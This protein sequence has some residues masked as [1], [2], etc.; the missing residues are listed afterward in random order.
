MKLLISEI[1]H[2]K[3][4]KKLCGM[5]GTAMTEADEFWKIYK[6]DVRAI[7]PNRELERIEFPDVIYCTE[8][9]KYAAIAD[10]PSIG[11]S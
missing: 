8:E 1:G 2:V 4:Y 10:E 9:E 3:L 5:T 11:V 6:L 7:P